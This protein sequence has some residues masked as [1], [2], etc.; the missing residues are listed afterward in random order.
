L[1]TNAS[2]VDGIVA[3]NKDKTLDQLVAEKKI[4]ADQKAQLLKKP[5]LEASLAQFR[6]QIEQYKKF[7]QEYKTASAAE[8]AQFEKTFS[9]RASKE[10]EEAVSAAKAEALATA[11]QE[12]E[13]AFLALS[14]FLRLA[15]V[16]RGEEEDQE[17]PENVALEALLV[18]VY[19]GDISAVG[20]MSKIIEGS[21]DSVTTQAGDV[22]SV[23][24]K[25]SAHLIAFS[26]Y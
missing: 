22:L 13:S 24:C 25:L 5:S 6:A 3:E 14:Q 2:K 16:R 20:A 8:K 15:A 11:K 17:L 7:D 18:K 12:Q 23:T 4:N 9:E 21:A 1:Q 10:L 19:T 26:L